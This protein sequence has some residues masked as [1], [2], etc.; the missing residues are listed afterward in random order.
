MI[1][2]LHLI[3]TL[4]VGGAE[5]A[6]VRLVTRL[7]PGRF[8]SAVVAMVDGGS[9]ARQLEA[10]GVETHTLHDARAARFSTVWRLG[11]IIRR[12]RPTVLQ[13]WLYHA[14]LLGLVA[15]RA[16]GV[17]AVAWNIRCSDLDWSHHARSLYWLRSL[18]AR[19]SR[20]PQAVVV[21]SEA[22]RQ[23]HEQLG[24]RPRRWA[25]IPNGFD[26]DLFTPS[27][28]HRSAVRLELG[29]AGD[30][31]VVGHVA[32]YHPMKDHRTFLA[33]MA[34]VAETRAELRVVLAGRGVDGGNRELRR[35]I[36]EERLEGRVVLAGETAQPARLLAAV[37]VTVSSSS[38]GEGFPNIVAESMACGVPVVGTDVGDTARI[39]G[40][41]GRVVGR[42]DAA[43]LSEAVEWLLARPLAERVAMGR[44][45]RERIVRDFSLEAVVG[46]YEQLYLELAGQSDE[47]G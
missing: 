42:R 18:L 21:N 20:G 32:R 33:A 4:E 41:D 43:A 27:E 19:L 37:D 10:S 7:D 47:G 14:D 39:I 25:L 28:S 35:A 23:L 24:Y 9:L 44:A 31:P 5:M 6:L 11:R 13:T 36:A 2:L 46:R 34:R 45:A 17:P 3:T 8:S 15:G 1:R 16:L 22:G 40:R 29:I 26:T 38:Y 30:A 12:V